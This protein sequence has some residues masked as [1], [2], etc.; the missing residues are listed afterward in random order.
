MTSIGASRSIALTIEAAK[1]IYWGAEMEL[2]RLIG[3][4]PSHLLRRALFRMKGMKMGNNSY[5]YSGAEVRSPARVA[6]GEGSI[7]GLRSTLDGRRGI[8]IGNHVNL[9]SEVAIWSLQHDPSEPGFDAVG[10]SVTIDDF[11]WISFRATILPGVQIGEGAVVAA[12]AVVTT[13][14]APWT[15]VG[16]VPAKHIGER[17]RHTS[18]RLGKP[19][20]I[21]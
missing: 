20:G 8:T 13:D 10:G 14:V 7:I 5:I 19:L 16:G 18:Y 17:P 15:I 4:I 12:G 1:R 11:A 6:V 2:L 3:V 9:S 21:V